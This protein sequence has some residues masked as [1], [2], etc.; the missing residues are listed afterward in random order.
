MDEDFGTP[1]YRQGGHNEKD[2]S[3]RQ[4]RWGVLGGNDLVGD[5]STGSEVLQ[6]VCPGS[7]DEKRGW[8]SHGFPKYFRIE[9]FWGG[10]PLDVSGKVL[11][12]SRYG[13][14]L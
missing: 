12:E 7:V 1:R 2:R 10:R 5:P 4:R 3:K 9:L 13:S 11:R 14:T 6:V 8:W